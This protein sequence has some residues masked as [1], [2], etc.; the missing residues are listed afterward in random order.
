M[1]IYVNTV[2]SS[3]SR[4]LFKLNEDDLFIL[5]EFGKLGESKRTKINI[6]TIEQRQI[7]RKC[8]VLQK[9]GFLYVVKSKPYRNQPNKQ[10]KTFGLSFKG[11]LASFAIKQSNIENNYYFKKYLSLFPVNLQNHIKKFMSLYIAE[12]LLYHQS[13]GLEI[14]NI[15]NLLKYTKDIIYDY[16]LILNKTDKDKLKKIHD[17]MMMIDDIRDLISDVKTYDGDEPDEYSFS[18]SGVDDFE[19]SVIEGMLEDDEPCPTKEH[20]KI[21]FLINFWPYVIDELGQ[22]TDVE[23]ELENIS[24]DMPPFGLSD[25]EEEFSDFANQKKSMIMEQ[26]SLRKLNFIKDY[27]LSF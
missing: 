20:V 5:S 4:Y 18:H 14:I 7:S 27:P 15:Q 10:N 17:D 25:Y 11:L 9:S 21:E 16:D 12:F 1:S 2:I 26:W 22:G 19:E 8:D 23:Y 13:I 3:A 24:N 6:G